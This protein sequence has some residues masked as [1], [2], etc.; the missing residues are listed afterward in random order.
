MPLGRGLGSLIPTIKSAL[1]AEATVASTE[2]N[3]SVLGNRE[4]IWQI[5]VSLIKANVYQPR[6]NFSH[7]SL[8]DLVNSIKEHGIL[9]PLLVTETADGG[10]ELIAGERR[11]RAGQ[12]AGLATVPALVREIKGV[13]KLELALIENIQRQDL[14]LLEEAFAYDRLIKE[15]DLTQEVVA[16]RVGK[17]RPYVG[18]VLRLINLPEEI[19]EGLVSGVI[20]Y[21][22]ARSLLGLE[23]K[24][25]Q[26]KMFRQLIGHPS[27][28]RRVGDDVAAMRLQKTGETRRDPQI[29]EYERQLRERLGTKVRI[30]QRRGKGS[31][32]I[33]YYSD[34]ELRKILK[35][36]G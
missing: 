3:A 10:Y 19:K 24:E 31:I 34:E 7:Q 28:S 14:N 36:L 35:I 11:W 26:V 17:S 20:N 30:T 18:N 15:F 1:R 2:Q 25:E 27:A 16:R 9:Q 22:T 4:Q 32:T 6:Q 21:T 23:T 13:A 33:D 12:M 29:L 5:P 8:E